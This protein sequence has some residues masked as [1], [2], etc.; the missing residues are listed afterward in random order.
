MET[1]TIAQ[2]VVLKFETEAT[3]SDL[4]KYT[5]NK[6]CELFDEIAALNLQVAGPQIWQYTGSDGRPDTKFKLEICVPITE[7]KGQPKQFVFDT[8]PAFKCLN[9][10][11][12]GEWNTMGDTYSKLMQSCFD[13]GLKPTGICREVYENCDFENQINNIT[14]VQVGIE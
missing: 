6:P 12:L 14:Q 1:K 11:H 13:N 3:L 2:Q 5:G 4:A 7:A 9:A 8:I 10:T